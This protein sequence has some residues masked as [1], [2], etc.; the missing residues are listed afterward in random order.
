ML[1]LV[2]KP[3]SLLQRLTALNP[4]LEGPECLMIQ[5]LSV[6]NTLFRKKAREI[7]DLNNVKMTRELEELSK[8][9]S[10]EVLADISSPQMLYSKV[11]QIYNYTLRTPAFIPLIKS[12]TPKCLHI[13]YDIFFWSY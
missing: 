6:L 7:I 12:T 13:E 11:R 5:L 2:I 1:Q 8:G 4:P 9:C 10:K 3:L